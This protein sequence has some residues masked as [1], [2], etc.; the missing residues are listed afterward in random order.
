MIQRG[1]LT[2]E[3]LRQGKSRNVFTP[4]IVAP[5]LWFSGFFFFKVIII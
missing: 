4:T 5:P 2:T 1:F 3:G